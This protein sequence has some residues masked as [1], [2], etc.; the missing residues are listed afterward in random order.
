MTANTAILERVKNIWAIDGELQFVSTVANRV[1]FSPEKHLYVHLTNPTHS[2]RLDLEAALHWMAFLKEEGA[3]FAHPVRSIQSLFLEEITEESET[4]LVSVFKEAKGIQATEPQYTAKLFT[5]WGR[6]VG[7]LHK[8]TKKYDPPISIKEHFKEKASKYH[9]NIQTLAKP[10]DGAIYYEARRLVEYLDSL[11]KGENEYGF[12][13]ADFH[14]GNFRV[15]EDGKI[16]LFDFD[17]CIYHWFVYDVAV[18]FGSVD[19]TKEREE[20]VWSG[21]FQEN[22]LDKEWIDALPEFYRYRLVVVYYFLKARLMEQR[23]G[24]EPPAWMR[25]EMVQFQQF[26]ED[27]GSVW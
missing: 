10:E 23:T 6:I 14:R 26:F 9:H 19:W 1:Y 15:D 18:I 12:I 8:A 25:N 5:E 16:T 4:Y 13:H 2:N 24:E 3:H 17:D 27:G 22:T 11:S 20:S 7:L 21:Y